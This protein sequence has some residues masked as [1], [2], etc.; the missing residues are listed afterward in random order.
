MGAFLVL[1]VLIIVFDSYLLQ[2]LCL[3]LQ[4]VCGFR[5]LTSGH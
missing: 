2:F 1:T 4:V 5:I 3:D